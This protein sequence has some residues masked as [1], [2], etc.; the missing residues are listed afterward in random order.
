MVGSLGCPGG[1]RVVVMMMMIE[2][3]AHHTFRARQWQQDGCPKFA[4]RK[5][6]C[7]TYS[8]C[9]PKKGEKG[10][11]IRGR[12]LVCILSRTRSA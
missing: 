11:R 6:S 1:G 3:S 2:E 4:E 12:D 10:T 5:V 9:S 8:S 7:R